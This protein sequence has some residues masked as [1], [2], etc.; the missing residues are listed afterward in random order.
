MA[1]LQ[2]RKIDDLPPVTRRPAEMQVLCLGMSRAATMCK[3]NQKCIRNSLETHDN[4]LSALK[5]AFNTLGYKSYHVNEISES[6]VPKAMVYWKE[7][8]EAKY[9]GKG[10]PYEKAEFDKLLKSYSVRHSH[11]F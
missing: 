2:R 1:S 6:G 9:L 8:I 3:P 4:R 5:N 10:K 7:A 11:P